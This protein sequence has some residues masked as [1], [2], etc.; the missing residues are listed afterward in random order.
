MKLGVITILPLRRTGDDVAH[1]WIGYAPQ[2]LQLLAHDG[3]LEAQLRGIVDVLPVATSARGR[4][5]AKMRAAR[6]DP[7]GRRFDHFDQARA[8]KMGAFFFD[9]HADD[10]A[11]QAARYKDRFAIDTAQ[12]RATISHSVQAQRQIERRV[13]AW[14]TLNYTATHPKGR[15]GRLVKVEA[16]C[17]SNCMKKKKKQQGLLAGRLLIV[18]LLVAMALYGFFIGPIRYAVTNDFLIGGLISMLVVFAILGGFYLFTLWLAGSHVLPVNSHDRSEAAAARRVLF[19]FALGGHVAMAVVREGAVEPG[20]NG[21]SREQ[22]GG[23]GVIDVDSTSAVA[24]HTPIGFSRVEGTGLVFT[25]E[26][27]QLMHLI[28]LR[29]QF[30]TQEF[31]F[32]TRDGIPIKVRLS[33]RFQ[34]DRTEFNKNLH[35]HDPKAPYPRPVK[36]SRHRV[37]RALSV[38]QVAD[39]EG[40]LTR[41]SEQRVI[42]TAQ[43][44][45]RA[46]IAEYTL[47]GLL[48]PQDP[49]RSPRQAIRELLS[50]R[51]TPVMAQRGIKIITVAVGVIFPADFDPEKTFDQQNPV[52]DKITEQ[53]LK[54]WRAEYE[55]RMFRISGE[56]QAEAERQRE[57][58]RAQAKLESLLRLAQAVEQDL[59]PTGDQDQITQHF[60]SVVE[61]IT[62][63]PKT[64]ALLDDELLRYM[65]LQLGRPLDF[66]MLPGQTD[67]NEPPPTT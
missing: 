49:G 5:P 54:A 25:H 6:C 23:M 40:N 57:K 18:I 58:A 50:H 21:E 8:R 60:W 14:H 62:K 67:S 36:W 47:D 51:L 41:W 16:L 26:T 52:L 32:L 44:M 53:R 13:G 35:A 17:Y 1:G 24:L 65:M 39:A 19:R 9:G 7:I 45:L 11:R 34:I 48:A 46:I 55:S 63:D 20:P 27:E 4:V 29:I 33:V 28:D 2:A 61:K 37:E 3:R 10:F 15:I 30:R 56:A 31:E 43:G 42:G 66:P 64:H 59:P 12:R 38:L 22:A